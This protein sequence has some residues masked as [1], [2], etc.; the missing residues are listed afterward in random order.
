MAAGCGSGVLGANLPLG[1]GRLMIW[2]LLDLYR[3]ITGRLK[4][5]QGKNLSV[6][7][8][9]VDQ[10]NAGFW[11]RFSALTV[12]NPIRQ[13]VFGLWSRSQH[14]GL[15]CPSVARTAIRG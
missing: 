6:S 2:W 11:V 13:S 8:P 9:Y 10:P 4:D 1:G 7:Q 15:D 14:G 12:D 5:K 3:I